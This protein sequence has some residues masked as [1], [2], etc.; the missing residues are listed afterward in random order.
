MLGNRLPVLLVV[1]VRAVGLS[2]PRPAILALQLVVDQAILLR[3]IEAAG[4]VHTQHRHL[5]ELRAHHLEMHPEVTRRRQGL[6]RQ[7][8]SPKR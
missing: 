7:W 4:P 6:Q 2:G 8:Q 1:V 5:N 3:D